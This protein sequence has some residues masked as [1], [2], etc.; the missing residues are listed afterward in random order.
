LCGSAYPIQA[1]DSRQNK[2]LDFHF[3][4]ALYTWN[5]IV[6]FDFLDNHPLDEAKDSRLAVIYAS[7]SY[8]IVFVSTKSQ[9]QIS[10]AWFF[11]KVV[12]LI[13]E[14]AQVP[15]VSK[16]YGLVS[17]KIRTDMLFGQLGYAAQPATYTAMLTAKTDSDNIIRKRYQRSFSDDQTKSGLQIP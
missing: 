14:P 13:Y 6:L 15:V 11:K 7:P 2:S 3:T 16:N 9:A 4:T 5:S 17:G 10:L 8:E 12:P 1:F